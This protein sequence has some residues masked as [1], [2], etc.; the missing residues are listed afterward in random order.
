MKTSIFDNKLLAR[1]FDYIL[2]PAILV[3]L[4]WEPNVLNGY[5]DHLESGQYLSGVNAILDGK[6]PY[7]DF[8]YLFGPLQLYIITVVMVLFGK[9]V[10]V[11]KLFFFT[12][13]IISF[14]VIYLLT[15]QV[16]KNRWIS[17][18]ISLICVIEIP[19]AFWATAFDYGRMALGLI[20]LILLIKFIKNGKAIYLVCAGALSGFTLFYTIDIGIFSVLSSAALILLY[21]TTEKP[22]QITQI[23]SHSLKNGLYYMAGFAFIAVPFLL[24]LA[25]QGGLLPYI[26]TA[27]YAIPKY[28]M[29]VWGQAV[30]PFPWAGLSASNTLIPTILSIPFKMYLPFLV[31]A[32]TSLY[33]AASFTAKRWDKDKV[34]ITLLTIYG[35]MIYWGSFRAMQTAQFLVALPPCIIIFGIYIEKILDLTHNTSGKRKIGAAGTILLYAII[36]VIIIYFMFSEKKYFVSID[37]WYEYQTRKKE[38]SAAY[39]HPVHIEKLDLVKPSIKW[40]GNVNIPSWQNE[41]FKFVVDYL[42]KNTGKDEPVF[43]FPEHAIYNFLAHRPAFS[44]FYIAA[45][46]WTKEDWRKELMEELAAHP[47]RV[48]VYSTKLSNLAISI[49]RKQEL[50]PEISDFI[51]KNYNETESFEGVIIYTLK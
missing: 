40:L 21:A 15:R 6:I 10:A 39:V 38:F 9:T 31:Y 41:Q 44:R 16:V 20:N 30:V 4:S 46:A 19:H 37:K 13:Y 35:A 34:I 3:M 22:L 33:L 50:L 5:I 28:H 42:D 43:T 49:G 26:Q 14:L 25:M 23:F 47:P 27:F 36:A 11:F 32:V 51:K 29:K 2:F 7:K 24:F 18:A 45:F 8:F 1:I 12:N 17:Y 48:I